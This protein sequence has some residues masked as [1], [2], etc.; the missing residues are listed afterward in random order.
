MVRLAE[1]ILFV[2][3]WLLQGRGAASHLCTAGVILQVRRGRRG[4]SKSTKI[5]PWLPRKKKERGEEEGQYHSANKE[6]KV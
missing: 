5:K 2:C 4:C 6:N 3:L 1:V